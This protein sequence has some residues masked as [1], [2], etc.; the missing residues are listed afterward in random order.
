MDSIKLMRLAVTTLEEI[1][2]NLPFTFPEVQD[3]KRKVFIKVRLEQIFKEDHE[4][5]YMQINEGV[6]TNIIPSIKDTKIVLLKK[7]NDE[8]YDPIYEY[9]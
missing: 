9:Y 6:I 8:R 3:Y 5:G 4:F 1:Q 7:I 2:L